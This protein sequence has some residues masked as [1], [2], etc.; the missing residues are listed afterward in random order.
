[1]PEDLE[2]VLDESMELLRQGAS[3]E[4]CLQRFPAHRQEL[5]PLLR[6][7]A[8]MREDWAK[9]QPAEDRLRR[10]RARFMGE[11]VK[12][13]E[14][15]RARPWWARWFVGLPRLAP[16]GGLVKGLLVDLLALLFL[17]ILLYGVNTAAAESL[18]GDLLYP[19]KRTSER[20]TLLMTFDE[21]KRQ[22]REAQFEKR[23]VEEVKIVLELGR[24]VE[25]DF[26]GVVEEIRGQGQ[27]IVVEGISVR[28]PEGSQPPAIGSKVQIDGQTE[29]EQDQVTAKAVEN[30]PEQP[31]LK[32]TAPQERPTFTPAIKPSPTEEPTET[33]TATPS[34]TETRRP[35]RTRK[36]TSTL[37]VIPTETNTPTAAHTPTSTPTEILWPTD[38]PEP[39]ATFTPIPP[40]RDIKVI[41]E[42]MVEEM[43]GG[44]WRVNG[45]RIRLSSSVRVNEERARAQVGSWVVVRAVKKPSGE[46]VAEEIEVLR[47]P[48]PQPREFNGEIRAM[49]SD[50]WV[51]GKETVL[52][53]RD[54]EIV[55]TPMI[56][57]RAYVKAE[58]YPDGR[59]V[60][61]RITVEE[62]TT[63]FQ[64]LL[65][66]M[67]DERWIVAGQ[68]I[69]IGPETKISGDAEIGAL[70]EV[71]A[72]KRADGMWLARSIRVLAKPQPSAT[73]V[74][75]DTPEPTAMPTEE[76]QEQ[77]A[78]T[79]AV[80]AGPDE[81]PSP[82]PPTLEEHLPQEPTPQPSADAALPLNAPADAETS[83]VRTMAAS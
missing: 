27:A 77:A 68:E 31:A 46:L 17:A 29:P 38:T 82:E 34:A 80:S 66:A 8:R 3:L 7:Y 69:V 19:V 63:E 61:R 23:R 39:T 79:M 10:V 58:L 62:A 36:P 2:N 51:I 16:S 55:G 76:S 18:P 78:P 60:A 59:L 28:L 74:P 1:M 73:P 25:V 42:G 54:T 12:R 67:D 4:E 33:P 24:V 56:G 32:A 45:Q 40:P 48:E 22:D 70:V 49:E 11:A 35:T 83:P 65:Q 81:S 13:R 20:V 21:Q 47:G 26:K 5:E 64:G 72:V 44:H 37:T 9:L 6:I 71:V 52:V 41:I 57:L 43:A 15:Q 50:R 75:T 53:T 30:V 14:A